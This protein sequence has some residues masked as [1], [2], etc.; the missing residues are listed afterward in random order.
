MKNCLLL[1]LLPLLACSSR[2]HN[3]PEA[4]IENAAQVAEQAQIDEVRVMAKTIIL[5]F[6]QQ[7]SDLEKLLENEDLNDEDRYKIQ[8]AM[9]DIENC[10]DGVVEALESL[11][12]HEKR[13]YE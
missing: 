9:D 7:R 2:L 8:D 13:L 6:K 11:D 5:K 12:W 1:L 4:T 10:E 3:F